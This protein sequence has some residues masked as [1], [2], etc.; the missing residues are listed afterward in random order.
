[1]LVGLTAAHHPRRFAFSSAPSGACAVSLRV[2]FER[3]DEYEILFEP[4]SNS[5]TCRKGLVAQLRSTNEL[6]S[7]IHKSFGALG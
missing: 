5:Q 6:S 4:T 7:D 3:A 1:M 2:D